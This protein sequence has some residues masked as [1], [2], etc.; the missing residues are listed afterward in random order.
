[1][2][3]VGKYGKIK[4]NLLANGK[5]GSNAV[6]ARLSI[7]M[8]L[9]ILVIGPTAW[10]TELASRCGRTARNT[11]GTGKM[12]KWKGMG[13]TSEKTALVMKDLWKR[14]YIMVKDYYSNPMAKNM[15]AIS[16]TGKR[17]GRD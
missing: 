15:M 10:R 12:M 14:I 6:L 3:K 8:G 11:K 9:S 4:L 5:R 17:R 13:S 7:V 16:K 2:D 1:M